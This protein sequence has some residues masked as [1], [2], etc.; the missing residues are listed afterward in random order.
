MPHVDIETIYFG[1][2]TP[3]LLTTAQL[4]QI[5]DTVSSKSPHKPK[6]ITLE[7]NPESLITYNP[8]ELLQS[9][10]NRLSIG[11]QSWQPEIL[12]SM[13]RSF[14][15]AQLKQ[16]VSRLHDNGLKNINLDHIIAYPGQSVEMIQND[17]EL[18]LSLNPTHISVYPLEIHDKT[19]LCQL[20]K[21]QQVSP[22]SDEA[23]VKAFALVQLTLQKHGYRHYEELNFA[24]PG[25]ECVHNFHFW[26]GKDY[27][28]LGPGAVS[29][30]G[31]LVTE[32]DQ[33]V[34][35]YIDAILN[36]GKAQSLVTKL[37]SHQS[38]QLIDDLRARLLT[39]NID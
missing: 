8:D 2:G 19:P 38:Q 21:D 6:E 39:E 36:L 17:I 1:G 3:S 32:N 35:N 24:I 12:A 9:G 15:P 16:Y 7:A 23:I 5:I 37:S 29:R 10:V 31:S 13:G 33:S 11:I 22:W 27:H 28:G 4:K 26:Q 18:S 14:D 20:V 34:D 25:Y 30:M